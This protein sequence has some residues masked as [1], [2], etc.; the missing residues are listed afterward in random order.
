MVEQIFWEKINGSW[1]AFGADG[2][3]K[4][5]W[6]YDYQLNSWYCTSIENGMKDG[7]YTDPQDRYTYYLEPKTGKLANG[8]K[9][10]DSHW[11]YFNTNASLRT[12]EL[13]E[14]TG[15]WNY[16]TMVRVKPYGAMYKNENTPDG[17]YVNNDGGWDGKTK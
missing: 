2:F 10:I 5:G 13:D 1:Y 3:L 12:W 7:W 9:Q 4:D 17:Y 6:V 14:A 16:N 8:W 15:K 11:Y